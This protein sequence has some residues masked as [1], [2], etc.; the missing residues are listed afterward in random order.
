MQICEPGK[1]FICFGF[2]WDNETR[3]AG[4]GEGSGYELRGYEGRGCEGNEGRGYEG[5]GLRGQGLR[6]EGATRG[7][8]YEGKGLRGEGATRAGAT[9]E[10]G[11]TR[12]RVESRR[13]DVTRVESR[14][15]AYSPILYCICDDI[16]IE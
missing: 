12:E 3:Y 6:G 8:G 15:C 11:G 9:R 7:R 2:V 16:G 4:K 13:C 10:R 5:K 14:G 1:L